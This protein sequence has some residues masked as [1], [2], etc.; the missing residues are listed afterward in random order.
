MGEDVRMCG[1]WLAVVTVVLFYR[2]YRVLVGGAMCGQ[3][4]ALPVG[5][6]QLEP[7]YAC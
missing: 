6:P 3:G 7:N 2:G 5:D 1:H 4:R